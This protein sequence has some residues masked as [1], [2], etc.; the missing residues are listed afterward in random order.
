MSS[1]FQLFL[2][3]VSLALDAFSVSVAGGIKSQKAKKLHAAK[4]AAFFGFFQAAMPLAGWIIG[5]VLSVLISATAHWIA[6]GLLTFIGIKMIREALSDNESDKKDILDNK[7]LTLLAIA[8][9]IDALIVGITLNLLKLPLLFSVSIIG[10]TTFVLSFFGYMFGNH[11]GK[12]FGKRVEVIGGIALIA[13]GLK[14]L[15][16]HFI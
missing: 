2:I 8:T 1:F 7:T 3:S 11:I 4:V 14:I 10:I 6:F 15:I 13:I 16:D 12:L 9:S 5:E